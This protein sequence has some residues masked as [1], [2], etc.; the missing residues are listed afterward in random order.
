MGN[1]SLGVDVWKQLRSEFG[2]L[3]PDG[4]SAW[5]VKDVA[6]LP[7]ALSPS[8]F[9]HQTAHCTCGC[10]PR[11]KLQVWYRIHIPFKSSCINTASDNMVWKISHRG[12]GD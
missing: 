4:S 7:I 5:E 12:D 3:S 6:L 8:L 1:V 9:M 10:P 11:P 2:K